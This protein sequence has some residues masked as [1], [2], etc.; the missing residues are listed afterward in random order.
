M[1]VLKREPSH[2]LSLPREHRLNLVE[3]EARHMNDVLLNSSWT[4]KIILDLMSTKL[5]MSTAAEAS[6]SVLHTT[7]NNYNSS[8]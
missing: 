3:R 1:T 7:H 5:L 8:P 6:V 2:L 4:Y